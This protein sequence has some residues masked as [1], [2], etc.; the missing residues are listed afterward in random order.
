MFH[1]NTIT[2]RQDRLGTHIGKSTQ[3]IPPVFKLQVHNL[4]FLDRADH[5]VALED[6]AI[7]EQGTFPE[8]MANGKGFSEMMEEFASKQ[9]EEEG[10]GEVCLRTCRY[11][12]RPSFLCMFYCICT[13]PV[14]VNH[15][16][17]QNVAPNNW[18]FA[19][20]VSQATPGGSKKRG[21]DEK[22]PGT[23]SGSA[24]A[25]KKGDG[26]MMEV[27]ERSTGGE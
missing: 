27:E 18:P 5:I 10:D 20:C 9:Q 21:A 2:L 8:L 26:K 17:H 11:R 12:N 14:L 7:S 4:A 16:F 24:R 23:P 22:E 25:G 13:E 3:K 15:R 6:Q 1:A 19:V